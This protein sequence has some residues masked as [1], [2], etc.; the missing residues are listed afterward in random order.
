MTEYGVRAEKCFL[1]HPRGE[2]KNDNTDP[3]QANLAAFSFKDMAKLG[4]PRPGKLPWWSSTNGL[5][6]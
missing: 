2:P 5:T 3:D 4:P 1:M 6:G